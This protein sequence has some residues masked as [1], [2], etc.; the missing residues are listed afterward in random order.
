MM[1]PARSIGVGDDRQRV[2]DA[3][4]IVRLIGEQIALKQKG[5]EYVC[6]CPFHDDHTPSM[7]VVPHKQMYHC[8]SCG[9]GGNAIGFVMNYHK[10]GFRESLEHLAERAG[11]TLTPRSL[12]RSAGGGGGTESSESGGDASESGLSRGDLLGANSVAQAFFRTILSHPEHGA[13]ARAV[14]EKR[15][16]TPEMIERFGVGGAPDKW[17]GLLLFLNSKGHAVEPFRAVG[18]LKSREN[19]SGMYDAFRNRLMFPILDQLGRVIG[20]GGRRL[21]DADEPKYINSPESSLFDKST[22]LYGLYQAAQ[23]IRQTRVAIVTEGY[24]DTI[25]CHQAGVTNAIATLGTAMTAGNARVLRRL[26]DTVVLLFDGDEAGQKAA[27]R[28]VEVFF[29]EPIDVK[30]AMLSGLTDAKDP[31]E[32]LKRPDGRAVFDRVIAQAIDPLELLFARVRKQ[33]GPLG[34]SARS[35]VVDEFIA[36]LMDLGLERTDK[37]RYQLIVKRLAQIANVDWAAITDAIDRQRGRARVRA[38]EAVQP[39]PLAPLGTPEHLLGCILNDPALTLTLGEDDWELIEADVFIDP[40]MQEV[41]RIVAD[42]TINEQTPSV[43]NVL[44]TT[45]EVNVQKA[46]TRLAAEVERFTQGNVDLLKHHWRDRLAEARLVRRK[47]TQAEIEPK[48]GEPLPIQDALARLRSQ[49]SGIGNDTRA[50][51]RPAS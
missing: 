24:M 10:M 13:A 20:F 7:C 16:L 14:V 31:D 2:L 36:R 35:R 42:L 40:W 25:A 43:S 41:A 45:D 8:F 17:D 4:D 51:P 39:Q 22:T 18:L 34:L 46:A 29:A 38:P 5:R 23:T 32:L 47:K 49:R 12:F 15:G 19:A 21:N 9:A 6:L 30:I 11:I 27:E 26:C 37:V 50:F 33:M 48:V 44:A 28:A 1:A 3:T